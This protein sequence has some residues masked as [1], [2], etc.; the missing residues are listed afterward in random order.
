MLLKSKH[1][2]YSGAAEFIRSFKLQKQFKNIFGKTIE[3]W[4]IKCFISDE[5]II[6][7]LIEDLPQK[8][9][10]TYEDYNSGGFTIH[11]IIN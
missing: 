9:L 2:Y 8:Y 3:E 5:K 4:E 10:C 11:K 6:H 1:Y 7:K